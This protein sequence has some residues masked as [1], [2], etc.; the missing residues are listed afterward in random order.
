[1]DSRYHALEDRSPSPILDDLDKAEP[2][3]YYTT[4]KDERPSRSCWD[5]KA[6]LFILSFSIVVNV[7]LLIIK[8]GPW[9]TD[10]AYTSFN[11]PMWPTPDLV[12]SPAQSAVK[13]ETQVY[14]QLSVRTKYNGPPTDETDEVWSALYEHDLARISTDEASRLANRTSTIRG[15]EAHH[16]IGLG[17]FHQ[18]HCLD[19]V[20]KAL[21]PIRYGPQSDFLGFGHTDPIDFVDQCLNVL[22]EH[23]IC[24]AD[25]TPNV[26]QWSEK[27]IIPHFDTVHVCRN[28]D[29][30]SD[31]ARE[32]KIS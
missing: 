12:Y 7:I 16:V 2:L 23:I 25:T 24:N 29:S 10:A 6:S 19:I 17:V 4:E 26:F 1:M 8:R 32:R 14:D 3:A 5:N 22:R 18:L 13:Y 9:I 28:W 11:D 31:W 15:D 30:I 21:W 20:R 27:M